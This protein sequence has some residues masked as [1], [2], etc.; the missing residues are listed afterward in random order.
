MSHSSHLSVVPGPVQAKAKN[1]LLGTLSTS[2]FELIN[3]YFEEL[4]LKC[5]Y[6]LGQPH[7]PFDYVYFPESAVASVVATTPDGHQIEVGIFGR[8]GMSATP[9]LLGVNESPH[10][11]YIQLE[12]NALRLSVQSLHHV[13][14]QSASL[15]QHLLRYVQVF[16]VQVAHTALS[17]GGYTIQARLARWLL[18]CHDRLDGNELPLIHDF[19]AL[20][21]GV[22]RPGVTEQLHHLEGMH[23]IRATRGMITVLSREKLLTIAGESYGVPEAEYERVIGQGRCG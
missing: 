14:A 6:V 5:G 13:I 17:H 7:I 12:G 19:L 10:D 1:R 21:L 23:A 8:E 20:M 9:V 4:S 11:T 16:N 2:D 18:M 15:H 22:R 3:P